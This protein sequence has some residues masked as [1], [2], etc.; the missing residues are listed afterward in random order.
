MKHLRKFVSILLTAIMVL[1]MCIPVMADGESVISVKNGDTHTYEV[2]QIFTGELSDGKLINVKWGQNANSSYTKGDKVE[3]SI[4]NTL[5]ALN[6]KTDTEKLDT[7]KAYANLTGGALG[8]VS[9]QNPLTVPNGYYLIK[10]NQ[11][12]SG[13]DDAESTYIVQVVG[14]DVEIE[15][16]AVKPTV[17]KQV[18][19]ETND[20]TITGTASDPILNNNGWGETADHAINESFK[21]K[22]IATLPA[23]KDY[24]SYNKYTVKFTDTMSEG[25]TFEKIDS[26]KVDSVPLAD[27]AYSINGV[28]KGDAGK[29]WTITISD[30]KT[31]NGVNLNDG[32]EVIVEYSAHLNEKAQVNYNT[33]ATDNKN[34]VY[35]EYSNNPNASGNGE[36]GKTPDDTVWVFTYGVN[37]TKFDATNNPKTPL[38]GVGFTLFD[39]ENQPV[40]LVL[41][42]D[43]YYY[44]APKGQTKNVVTEMTSA[45]NGKF[46]IKGLDVGQ[47]TLKETKVPTG[48]NPC[49]DKTVI[50]Q[51]SHSESQDGISATTTLSSNSTTT[52]EIDNKKGSTLPETGGIGTTIFYIVGVVLVL[53]AGVLLVTKKRMN[54]DK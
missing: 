31:I 29:T 4:L 51:A 19:D 23:S 32:A 38:P 12:Y 46:N 48:Y 39:S 15:R 17:D 9:A 26:V 35:L 2:Y 18:Q 52:F 13:Q 24:A 44:P 28:Q 1:A 22:L 54:A 34:T 40:K 45:K 37:N 43:G 5:S 53:G 7:I 16:K 50:I 33:G 21:F 36:F 6:S 49:E 27:G 41:K 47:Y 11:S 8:T 20:N 10:E 14:Q 3:E 25:V 42:D 30:L